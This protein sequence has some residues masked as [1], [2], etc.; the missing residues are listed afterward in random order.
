[1]K[2]A[3]VVLNGDPPSKRLLH[4][5]ARKADLLV[6]ADGGANVCFRHGISPDVII[7]DLDSIRPGVQQ[8]FRRVRTVRIA[9]QNSTDFEKA[10][11]FLRREKVSEVAVTGMTGGRVDF[12]LGNF[13]SLWR[14]LP[15]FDLRVFGEGWFA[16][17]VK[18]RLDLSV[19]SGTVV[20]L[21]PFGRATG[22]TLSG[23]CYP[24]SHATLAYGSLGVSNVT[25]RKGSRVTLR[26]GRLLAVVH[27][28]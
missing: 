3:L 23:F 27:S 21:L 16:L 9:E 11:A 20:S 25:T 4:R 5:L 24:L 22:V 12:T 19:P 15:H 6:A 8:R 17:P 13:L 10:L 2:R 1:M 26:S 18:S 7:G 28:E 14:F